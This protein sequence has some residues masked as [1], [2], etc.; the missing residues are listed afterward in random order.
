MEK[1][2]SFVEKTRLGIATEATKRNK[3]SFNAIKERGAKEILAAREALIEKAFQVYTTLEGELKSIKPDSAATFDF[4]GNQIQPAG[5]S[6]ATIEKRTKTQKRFDELDA[7][8]DKIYN[9]EFKVELSED[10]N[11]AICERNYNDM[12]KMLNEQPS[13][14]DSSKGE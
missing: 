2:Q 3:E 14:G 9:F 13:K 4:N 1:K 10:E 7:L 5:F 12:K 11:N 8:I 6:K